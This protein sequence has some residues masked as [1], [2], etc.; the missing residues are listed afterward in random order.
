HALSIFGDHS[1][2]M[3]ARSSG[4]GMLASNSV[5]EVMDFALI[6][7]AASLESR[8]PFLH[9]FD[10][11]RTSHEIQKIELPADEQIS[12]MIDESLVREH[13]ARALSPEHPVIRGTAQNPDVFFQAREAINPFYDACPGIVQQTMDRFAEVTGRQY[14]LFDYYGDPEAARVVV[15]MGSAVETALETAEN[16][17]R[18]GARVGVLA[19][20]LYRPFAVRQFVEALPRTVKSIAVLDRTKEPGAAGEPLYQDAVI[21]LHEG[22]AQGWTAF[23]KTP[24]VIGGRYGL[25]SKEFTPAMVKAIFD[26]L[27]RP[28]PKNHFT[29]GILDDVSHTSIEF[30]PGYS[31]ES[32]DTFR[33]VFFGLGSDGTVSANKSSIKIIGDATDNYAQGFFVYDSK[34]AGSVTVSHLRFGPRPIHSTYLISAA[35]FVACHQFNFLEK[36]D[37]LDK[38]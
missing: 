30:D 14:R 7:Q 20:R 13:R 4:F 28:S 26:E 12:A 2:V 10:G 16:L 37:I 36:F 33:G 3:A 32:G 15:L 25:S 8:V 34:K 6:S 24:N 11:F 29:A 22:I 27:D 23:E 35:N 18:F 21:A 31:T 5:Q 1:D 9:F 19:V 17:N 38:A